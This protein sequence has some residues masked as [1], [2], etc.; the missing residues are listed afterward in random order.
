MIAT[1]TN[2][3]RLEIMKFLELGH[4]NGVQV[5]LF[6]DLKASKTS[7]ENHRNRTIMKVECLL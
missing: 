4:I 7:K 3:H 6:S 5:V 1:D 2:D